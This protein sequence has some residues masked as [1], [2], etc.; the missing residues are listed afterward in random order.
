MREQKR[1]FDK[2]VRHE[3]T[4]QYYSDLMTPEYGLRAR[5]GWFFMNF[6]ATPSS[7][8]NDWLAMY[9]QYSTIF[10]GALG[11]HRSLSFKMFSDK[12]LRKSLDQVTRG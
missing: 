10:A 7:A 1:E 3:L 9:R 8:V 5:M 12:A 4:R 11:N 2:E 6:Y